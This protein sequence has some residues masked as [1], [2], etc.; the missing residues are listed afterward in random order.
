MT[1]RTD[2]SP[3]AEE[4]VD[5]LWASYRHL[6]PKTPAHLARYQESLDRLNDFSARREE[7]L[8]DSCGGILDVMWLVL[9]VGAALTVLFPCQ[10]GVN[11]GRIHAVIIAALATSL[12]LL[13]YLTYDLNHPFQGDL[14]VQPQGFAQLLERIGPGVDPAGTSGGNA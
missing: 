8:I 13:R 6:T 5:K 2:S 12:G 11:S 4:Q 9:V 1:P 7:R 10:F 3:R 14:H